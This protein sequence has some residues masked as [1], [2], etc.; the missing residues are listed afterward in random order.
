MI[1]VRYVI[2]NIEIR[3]NI[4]LPKFEYFKQSFG[5]L[6]YLQFEFPSRFDIG[7]KRTAPV[8]IRDRTPGANKGLMK[9]CYLRSYVQVADALQF[10]D[11]FGYV[12]Q[13]IFAL[14]EQ[15]VHLPAVGLQLRLQA[16]Q[17]RPLIVH[18]L[19]PF[20]QFEAD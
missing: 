2:S 9:G 10:I 7:T 13:Q 19:R 16:G 6:G 20:G 18:F 8:P 5:K 3:R 17:F 11:A 15:L 1:I 4:E 14:R 12:L